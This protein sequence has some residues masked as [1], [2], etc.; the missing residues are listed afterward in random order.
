MVCSR[1]RTQPTAAS[2]RLRK[3]LMMITMSMQRKTQTMHFRPT[4]MMGRI[5]RNGRIARMG[6]LA[7]RQII[8]ANFEY[9]MILLPCVNCRLD[10]I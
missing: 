8:V 7:R 1:I 5:M 3:T 10:F 2:K 4:I 9:G 6:R